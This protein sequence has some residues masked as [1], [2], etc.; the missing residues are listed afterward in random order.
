[1]DDDTVGNLSTARQP[2]V[3]RT[4]Y[5]KEWKRV[6]DIYGHVVMDI[7]E[8]RTD[9]IWLAARKSGLLRFTPRSDGTG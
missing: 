2:N 8:D 6:R 9:R 3:T 1:M 7:K 5:L 4:L